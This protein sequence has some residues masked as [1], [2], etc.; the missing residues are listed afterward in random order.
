MTKTCSYIAT[1]PDEYDIY[2]LAR[3]VHFD[4]LDHVDQY[5]G[6][7]VITRD[8][9]VDGRHIFQEY[10]KDFKRA[11]NLLPLGKLTDDLFKKDIVISSLNDVNMVAKKTKSFYIFADNEHVQSYKSMYNVLNKSDNIY[12]LIAEIAHA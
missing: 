10:E 6:K 12:D 3:L 7:T 11:I 2:F 4:L 8:S 5:F 1:N 9:M